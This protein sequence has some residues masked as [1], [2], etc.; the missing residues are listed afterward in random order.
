M[1]DDDDI[2]HVEMSVERMEIPEGRT[3]ALEVPRPEFVLRSEDGQ[4][5]VPLMDMAQIV[6]SALY[7]LNP[8]FKEDFGE[9]SE[10]GHFAADFAPGTGPGGDPIF[11]VT[12]IGSVSPEE[13]AEID[14]KRH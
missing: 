6:L 12:P 5:I 10:T 14:K 1:T 4:W 2:E 8:Q 13:M 9:P 11:V 7:Q 3:I